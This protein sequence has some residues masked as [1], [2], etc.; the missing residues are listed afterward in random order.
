MGSFYAS[1]RMEDDL[2]WREERERRLARKKEAEAREIEA[3]SGNGAG[4]A[5]EEK[6]EEFA[7]RDD[8]DIYF[9]PERGNVIFASAIDGWA[10]RIGS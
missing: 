3:D 9:A 1:E 2:R 4:N 7:E 6:E 10:F 5:E 8:E